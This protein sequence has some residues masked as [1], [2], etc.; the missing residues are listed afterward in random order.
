VYYYNAAYDQGTDS[1]GYAKQQRFF[2]S[3]R[4]T[5]YLNLSLGRLERRRID[6]TGM[7]SD[8]RKRIE[9]I[10]GMPLPEHT[11]VEKGVDTQLAVDMIRLAVADTY[12]IAVLISGDGDFAPAVEFVKQLGKQVELGRVSRWPC[13]RLRDVCDVEVPIE[14]DM[15]ESC[16]V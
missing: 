2:T 5:P 14:E 9:E 12:D 7:R 13:N 16:W 11:Y 1:E 3:L 10:L 6:Y 15:L 8:A 4:R